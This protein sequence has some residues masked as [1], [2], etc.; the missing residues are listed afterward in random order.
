MKNRIREAFET[1]YQKVYSE[2]SWDSSGVGGIFAMMHQ[3]KRILFQSDRVGSID[4]LVIHHPH[5]DKY[6]L[7]GIIPVAFV[8]KASEINTPFSRVFRRR[9]SEICTSVDISESSIRDGYGSAT[10]DWYQYTVTRKDGYTT[11]APRT[12]DVSWSV[13]RNDNLHTF[14]F[15]RIS[16]MEFILRTSQTMIHEV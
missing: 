8:R 16:P 7:H 12:K 14:T 15:I 1:I 9:F 10:K 5:E 6:A 13:V 3:D 4:W 2:D 11:I